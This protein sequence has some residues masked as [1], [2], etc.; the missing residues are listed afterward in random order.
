MYIFTGKEGELYK[1][2]IKLNTN[3]KTVEKIGNGPGSCSGGINNQPNETPKSLDKI[4]SKHKLDP[5]SK[6]TWL[7]KHRDILLEE[8]AKIQ[9]FDGPATIVDSKTFNKSI[10]DNKFKNVYRGFTNKTSSEKF[11]LGDYYAGQG[12]SGNGIYVSENKSFAKRYSGE[13][14]SILS[15]AIPSNYNIISIEKLFDERRSFI[16]KNKSLDNI[17]LVKKFVKD[18]GRFAIL[19]GYDAI[20]IP[21]TSEIIILNRSGL[22]VK[23]P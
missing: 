12:I 13:S 2:S 19:M 23:E 10:K 8:F 4:L 7:P 9:K 5:N 21:D 18:A 17:D 15:I 6:S 1:Y 20:K 16:E 11:A 3:C 22:L 14:G